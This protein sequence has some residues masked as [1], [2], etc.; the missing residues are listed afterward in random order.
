MANRP[1]IITST[2]E[3]TTL[4]ARIEPSAAI[5]MLVNSLKVRFRIIEN[6]P[7]P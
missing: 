7:R 4:M 3:T 6:T 1:P 5:G 2:L